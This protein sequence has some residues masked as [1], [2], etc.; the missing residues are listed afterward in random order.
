M[1]HFRDPDSTQAG[2]TSPG[3]TGQT[4]TTPSSAPAS[5]PETRSRRTENQKSFL[6]FMGIKATLNSF[7]INDNSLKISEAGNELNKKWT[8][9]G[10]KRPLNRFRINKTTSK[11]W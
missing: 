4:R 8:Y 9:F 1:I 2:Q 3:Q 5:V 10:R 7:A 11:P 6:D